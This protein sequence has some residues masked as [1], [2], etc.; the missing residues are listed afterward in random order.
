[1]YTFTEWRMSRRIANG[2]LII[3]EMGNDDLGRFNLN[4]NH[5]SI[6][7]WQGWKSED[8]LSYAEQRHLKKVLRGSDPGEPAQWQSEMGAGFAGFVGTDY[9]GGVVLEKAT[10]DETLVGGPVSASIGGNVCVGAQGRGFGPQL[11]ARGIEHALSNL[12]AQAVVAA[13]EVTNQRCRSALAK[14]GMS[15]VEGPTQRVLPNGRPVTQVWFRA[16][17]R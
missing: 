1:M 15:E 6:L 7:K 16:A 10:G 13:C 12:G 14:A 9:V 4:G 5:P 3:R 17:R 8:L 11:F 2:Q